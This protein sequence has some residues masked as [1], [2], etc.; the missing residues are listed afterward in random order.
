MRHSWRL[1][2]S[3][4]FLSMA[5]ATRD[6]V[7]SAPSD[8]GVGATYRFPLGRVHQACRDAVVEGGYTVRDDETDASGNW[9]ILATQGIVSGN[10]LCRITLVQASASETT[11]R[12]LVES[13]M[14]NADSHV[15]DEALARELQ[16]RIGDRLK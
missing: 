6:S 7:R 14:A 3:L 15:T 13:R 1:V 4:L 11:A 9:R 2:S 5:C 8:S 10:R 12:V 16:R